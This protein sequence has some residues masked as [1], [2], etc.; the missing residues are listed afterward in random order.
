MGREGLNPLH[1]RPIWVLVLTNSSPVLQSTS[2]EY[3]SAPSCLSNISSIKSLFDE[4]LNFLSDN[5]FS[6]FFLKFIK[7]RN[8]SANWK[9]LLKPSV[10]AFYPSDPYACIPAKEGCSVKDSV[11]IWKTFSSHYFGVI[12]PINTGVFPVFV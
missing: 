11:Q 10:N 9:S 2:P 5:S 3:F 8:P 6:M 1:I 12:T 7:Q 4:S